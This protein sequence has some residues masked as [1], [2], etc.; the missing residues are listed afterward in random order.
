[1]SAARRAAALW[2]GRWLRLL[3][4]LPDHAGTALRGGFGCL[5]KPRQVVQGV[6]LG[7]GGVLLALRRELMCWELPGGAPLRSDADEAAALVRELREETGLVIEAGALVGE[8]RRSGFLSHRARVFRCRAVSGE[9]RP[10]PETPRVAWW[11]L[12]ALPATLLPWHRRPLL[13]AMAGGA[14]VLRQ[15]HLGFAA[16]CTGLRMDWKN[17]LSSSES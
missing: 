7:P 10:G 12:S 15:E 9:L 14:P 3:R 16:I 1:V 11:P 2:P 6:V 13:D 17:R 5:R 8:Y 4:W